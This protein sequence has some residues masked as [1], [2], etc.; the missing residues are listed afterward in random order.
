MNGVEP[1]NSGDDDSAFSAYS[2]HAKDSDSGDV[3]G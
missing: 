3:E 1:K 2:H